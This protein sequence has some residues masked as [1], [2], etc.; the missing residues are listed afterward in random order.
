MP[1]ANRGTKRHCA[2]CSA[3]YYD[4][5]R[6]P[7]VCPKCQA[8]FVPAPRQMMRPPRGHSRA[9]PVM[10]PTPDSETVFAEDE[11]VTPGED[12][13]EHDGAV[14]GGEDEDQDEAGD[15]AGDEDE[16]TVVDG[17]SRD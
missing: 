3:A 11:A 16:E 10:R 6:D 8:E 15:D 1:Q 12:E 4:L 7:P 5:G 14:L 9:V 13:D 17:E 2:A